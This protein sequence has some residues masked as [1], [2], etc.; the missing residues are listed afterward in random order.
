MPE[1]GRKP[2]ALAL[3]EAS[4]SLA[5]LQRIEQGELAPAG[6]AAAARQAVRYL[7]EAGV[8][9]PQIGEAM[10][11]LN[12]ALA[13]TVL[14]RVEAEL[15]PPPRPC[16]LLVYGSDGRREQLLPTDQDNA[17]VWAGGVPGSADAAA[18][19]YFEAVADRVVE[20]LLTAGF[21]PCPGG[22]MATRWR[23][24]LAEAEMLFAGWLEQPRPEQ[25][26]DICSFFD[27]RVAAGELDLKPLQEIR[28]RA[29][30][31]KRLL[32]L[33]AADAAGLRLPLGLLGGLREGQEGFDLKRG[34]L[35]IVSLARLFAL[36]AGSDEVGT[37]NRLRAAET[38]LGSDDAETLAEAF[39]FLVGLRLDEQLGGHAHGSRVELGELNAM[40][41]SFLEDVFHFLHRLKAALPQ[42]FA[43]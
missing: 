9:A 20:Q 30:G 41:I 2:L 22:Y 17:L 36:E 43:L 34:I 33:L 15:G 25:V 1:A 13:R 11:E 18:R 28:R 38:T 37:L 40:E 29:A 14:R 31:A 35:L 16:A 7:R 21:P 42:R 24:P 3:L 39:R 26:V 32:R 4:D 27:F 12:D 10:A 5:I 8:E 23:F 19:D 6:Y